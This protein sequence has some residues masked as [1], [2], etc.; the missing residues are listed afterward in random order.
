MPITREKI[1]E[2]SN[3]QVRLIVHKYLH[4]RINPMW[5]II[6]PKYDEIINEDTSKLWEELHKNFWRVSLV[7]NDYDD[8]W[9]V[10]LERRSGH[11]EDKPY[12]MAKAETPALA[13]CRAF[14]YWKM[15]GD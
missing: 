2:L 1:D 14:L 8:N 10:Y 4:G 9:V 6:V 13:L 12:V 7:M 5:R 3:L 15:L 11:G